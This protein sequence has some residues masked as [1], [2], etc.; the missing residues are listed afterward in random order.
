MSDS[1]QIEQLSHVEVEVNELAELL[2][3]VVNGGA[4]IG[5]LPPMEQVDAADYWRTVL[6]PDIILLI[7]RLQGRIVGSVQLHLSQKQNGRHRAEIAK[8]M[9]HPSYRRNGVGRRLMERVEEVAKQEQRSLIVLDTREGDPSNI[10]YQSL[11][12]IECGRIPNYA[13]SA[14][15]T[16]AATVFYYKDLG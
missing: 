9:T 3:H 11:G 4:S 6:G 1:I 15:G 10:L 12:Y 13:V 14:D 8:L 2:V 16:L 5:F 7:A